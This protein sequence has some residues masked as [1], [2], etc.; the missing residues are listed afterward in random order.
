MLDNLFEC[1]WTVH[2]CAVIWERLEHSCC[3]LHQPWGHAGTVL[4]PL[5]IDVVMNGHLGC[6]FSGP[7][8]KKFSVNACVISSAVV[9]RSPSGSLSESPAQPMTLALTGCF[10]NGA[11]CGQLRRY[12]RRAANVA[13]G[14]VAV[15]PSVTTPRV[16]HA[17]PSWRA[18]ATCCSHPSR[19]TRPRQLMC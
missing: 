10:C 4:G 1:S 11:S 2:S 7:A 8:A 15:L 6:W 19:R 13:S 14:A 5:V 18:T 9:W 3:G 16:C 17:P 12:N